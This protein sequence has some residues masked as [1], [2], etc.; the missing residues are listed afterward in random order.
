MAS[1]PENF[2]AVR[3]ATDRHRAV[4]KCMAYPFDDGPLLTEFVRTRKPARI[5]EIGAALGYSA[6]SMAAGYEGSAV[7]TIERDPEHVRLAREWI[8][9]FDMTGRITVIQDDFL[10]ALE[11]LDGLYDLVFFD[12]YAP[13]AELISKL[14]GA[15]APSG[16]ML[17]TNLLLQAKSDQFLT[18]LFG[19][20]K[21]RLNY[22]D[23]SRNTACCV[24]LD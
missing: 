22:I 8:G 2:A 20:A 21:W 10:S 16:A 18:R 13:T 14:E 17:V 3:D 7:D 4:H 24:R 6:L 15:L 5:L 19:S 11:G 1:R 23:K 12:G 9:R